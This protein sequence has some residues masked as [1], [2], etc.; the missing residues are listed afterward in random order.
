MILSFSYITKF[1]HKKL[2]VIFENVAFNVKT[3]PTLL[4]M[5]AVI[6]NL[7]SQ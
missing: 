7:I 2:L 4:K 1:E 6:Y 5:G 3:Y